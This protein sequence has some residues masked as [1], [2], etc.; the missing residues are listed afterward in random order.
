MSRSLIHHSKKVDMTKRK[1]KTVCIVEDF[2]IIRT[3]L[4]LIFEKQTDYKVV[5]EGSAGEDA[6]KFFSK[7]SA[8]LLIIDYM[9]PGMNGLKAAEIIKGVSPKTK[10][11][12]LTICDD[13]RN[14][15]KAAALGVEGYL[16]KNVPL[17]SL[18]EHI[19]KIDQGERVY[20]GGKINLPEQLAGPNGFG[21]KLDKLTKREKQVLFILA[22]G[23]S[24]RDIAEQ[25]FISPRTVEKHRSNI[26]TKLGL[27]STAELIKFA[28]EYSRFAA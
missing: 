17:E 7:Q 11:I 15:A 13:A 3:G 16:L 23:K 20:L 1:T 21:S 24:S 28:A 25:L 27:K 22:E 6:V 12:I 19:K 5:G 9:L 2:E 4:K 18:A 10:I 26:L 14:L 8:D